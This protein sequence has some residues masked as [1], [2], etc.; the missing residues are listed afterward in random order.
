MD[1]LEELKNKWDNI[2][3]LTL[4]LLTVSARQLELAELIADQEV[5]LNNAF[6]NEKEDSFKAT[7][8]MAKAR[9]KSLIGGNKTKY[10]YEFQ[11]LNNLMQTITL[12]ISQL[13]ALQREGLIPP[14][15]EPASI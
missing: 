2:S 7:D 14:L 15:H 3:E 9:A 6:V 5:A 4:F 1:L 12:R 13:Q 8:A 11:A 10:E